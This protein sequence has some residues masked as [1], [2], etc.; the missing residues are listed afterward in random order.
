MFFLFGSQK[1]M[2]KLIVNADDF[3]L[4]S[5]INRGIIHAYKNGIVTSTSLSPTGEFFSEAVQ[6]IKN[7]PGID[8]GIHLTLIEEKSVL[9]KRQIPTLV[10]NDCLFRKTS[11]HFFSDYLLQRISKKEIKS[12]L[13]AQI[14][15]LFDSGIK[16]THIDSHQHIH[17]LPKIL[18]VTIEL[19][20][21]YGIRYIRYPNEKIEV[22]NLLNLKKIPRLLQQIALNCFCHY[23]KGIMKKYSV[24]NFYGFKDG[25]HLTKDNLMDILNKRVDGISEIMCHPAARSDGRTWERYSHWNFNWQDELDGLVDQ[26]ILKIVENRKIELISF[27]K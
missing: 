13:R 27:L 7:N 1:V 17:M 23:S 16:I 12:E 11:Y 3:G 21:E 10:D 4:T 24:D 8:V 22:R 25:G 2:Q 15:K 9:P 20:E 18:K 26:D 6:L 19:A 5:E 14:E